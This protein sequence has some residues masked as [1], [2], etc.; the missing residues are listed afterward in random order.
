MVSKIIL[1]VFVLLICFVSTQLLVQKVAPNRAADLAIEQIKENGAREQL[2]IE[3]NAQ[4]YLDPV[5]YLLTIGFLVWIWKE[6][7]IK[8]YN[9]MDS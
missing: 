2:R 6:P 9:K 3:Q 4:N 8:L 5:A 7:V 1:T